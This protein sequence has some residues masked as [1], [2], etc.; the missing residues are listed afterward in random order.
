M[1]PCI[2]SRV[3]FLAYLFGGGFCLAAGDGQGT[4]PLESGFCNP[5][6]EAR[7]LAWWH[8]NNGNISREGIQA[9]LEAMAQ[10]GLVGVQLFDL[11]AGAPTGPVRYHS[12]AWY[13][14]VQFAIQTSE[15]LGLTID[16]MNGPGFATSGGPWVTPENSMKSFTW[17]EF[18][19]AGPAHVHAKLPRPRAIPVGAPGVTKSVDFYRDAALIAVPAD[20]PAD[21]P[22]T[23]TLS[24]AGVEGAALTDGD[25]KTGLPVTAALSQYSII[26]SYSQPVER[27]LLELTYGV[28]E[29]PGNIRGRIEASEDGVSFRTVRDFDL[30]SVCRHDTQY[31]LVIPFDRTRARAFRVTLD[32]SSEIQ[33]LLAEL[34]L[35]NAVRL[36]NYDG[37]TIRS[38]IS[39]ARPAANE[40]HPDP[41][42]IAADRVID[43]TGRLDADGLLDWDVP[44]GR[45]TILRC[46]YTSTGAT[47]HPISPESSGLEVDK[48][49]SAAVRDYFEHSLGRI[50][51]EAGPLA[52][53]ILS[54][55]LLDSWEAGRQ[56]WCANFPADFQELRGY[57]ITPW[58]PALT[59]RVVGS[60][61]ETEAFL[62]DYR[63]TI[64][65]LI[66]KNYYGTLRRI[67]H[68]HGMRLFAE[69]Y[70]STSPLNFFRCCAEADVNMG[71]FWTRNFVR[72]NSDDAP[73]TKEFA[74][75]AHVLGRPVFAAEAFT[76]SPGEAWLSTPGSLK[77]VGDYAFIYG[78]NRM[79]L[80]S[81]V[82]QWR[83]DWRPGLTLDNYGTQFG[84]L[85]TW[86]PLARAWI[87]YLS[88]CQFLLQQGQ[89]RADLLFLRHDDMD[90]FITVNYFDLL[91]W[92]T[93][94]AGYDFDFIA[95]AQFVQTTA[96][97]NRIL[98]PN[99][100][101]Y[102]AIVL[103][104]RWVADVALL[105]HLESLIRSG[106]PKFGPPPQAPAG[107]GDLQQ[108][109]QE[110][111]ELVARLWPNQRAST[112]A[113]NKQEF[114]QF[115]A[116]HRIEPDC[117]FT[118]A[119]PD[120]DVRYVHRATKDADIYFL[121]NQDDKPV[122]LTADFRV[123]GRRPELWDPIW[124]RIVPA[125]AYRIQGNRTTLDL[126]LPPVGS[127]FV[128][129]R[130]PPPERFVTGIVPAAAD[131]SE[132]DHEI[133]SAETGVE[134]TAGGAYR[135][136]F[137]D[138]TAAQLTVEPPPAPIAISAAWRVE[139]VSALGDLFARDFERL[140]SWAESTDEAERY[141]SGTATYR[142]T[143]T[144]P[145]AP[146][147]ADVRC[148]LEL[149]QV[150]DLAE[151]RV[152]GQSAGIV[153]TRPFS[154][155]VTALVKPGV[156]S[157][158]IAATNTWVNGLIG[159]ENRVAEAARQTTESVPAERRT[160]STF[161]P[162]TA[163][164]PLQPSGLLG[165]VS[166]RF[167]R[168]LSVS[169]LPEETAVGQ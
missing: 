139:F 158:E 71:E 121:S 37:K 62:A 55:V 40:V 97:G 51:R 164:S 26:L 58:L 132:A 127:L 6:A 34:R 167:S 120:A 129:F 28:S 44:P 72:K 154:V 162:Y 113:W 5:P 106:V 3:V 12:D 95:P 22:C 38:V 16:L 75:L 53:R 85:V 145:A 14:H 143:F 135:V 82:H 91:P 19:A 46:G 108:R 149:G 159:E 148:R 69:C 29:R 73:G 66:A 60:P 24:V 110:W 122:R 103:P 31:K 10:A 96:D 89:Y 56:T 152:N 140:H 165:P 76:A 123:A 151:V 81:V 101:P 131:A 161:R 117:R 35:S 20:A 64:V 54:G 50:I 77:Q 112:R 118:G 68:D 133:R 87:D 115:L 83:S 93:V 79:M 74:S 11:A 61:A 17:S 124:G 8:W 52:G 59:G 166:L 156:N 84:R 15:K 49:D 99:G 7:P 116:E 130:A 126:A 1:A 168:V 137:N 47:N 39:I 107:L 92:P 27:R 100:A 86:W 90:R 125:A 18:E 23:P 42:A 41:D 128:V 94:P 88:R 2:V 45:W 147:A 98:L 138:G 104:H 146:L 134:V 102:L 160:V 80:H 33:T 13:D 150:C 30:R 78:V 153:W 25:I 70:G 43:L 67:A 114:E 32:N 36:E 63:R 136:D 111:R 169:A 57:N 109:S 65:D 9:D 163:E 141:F 105:R 119:P 144:L 4:S 48:M 142:T 157:L 155:D 21:E